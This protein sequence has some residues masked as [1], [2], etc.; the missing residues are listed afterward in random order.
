LLIVALTGLALP[1]VG[2]MQPPW[3]HRA[4]ALAHEAA[5]IVFLIALPHGKLIHLFIRPL[6]VG[7]KLVRA[8]SAAPATCRGCGGPLAPAAQIETIETLLAARGFNFAGHQ[9]H[10]PPCRRRLLA[11]AQAARLGSDFQPRP[12]APRARR[13]ALAAPALHAKSSPSGHAS[14]RPPEEMGA[15]SA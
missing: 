10:C 4:A 14:R 5:V 11:G 2:Q 13:S 9:R 12:A 1:V 3:L 8:A 7:A 6:Q 15:S